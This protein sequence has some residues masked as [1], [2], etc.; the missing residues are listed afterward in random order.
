MQ[1]LKFKKIFLAISS[2]LVIASIVGLIL[3]KLQ[4]SI[5]FTGGSIID[6]TTTEKIDE[7]G[8]NDRL[9][10]G[11][12]ESFILRSTQD[13]F[14]LRTKDTGG[15]NKHNLHVLNAISDNKLDTIKVQ[16]YDTIGPTLGNE[17]KSKAVVSLILVILAITLF[18]AYS[19]RHVSKPVNSWKYGIITMIALVHDVV[20][21]LGVFAF[22]GHFGGIEVDS[23]FITAL[24]VIL[25]Y[26]INDTIVVFDRIREN[27]SHAS[28]SDKENKFDEIVGKSLSETVV[29]SINTSFTTLLATAIVLMFTT[30]SV[31]YFAIA[32]LVGIASGTYSSIF[33]AAPLLTYFKPKNK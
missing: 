12:G 9:Q 10:K 13:G 28:D 7:A 15:D 14:S 22:M 19:F 11:L 1:I 30:G 3:Y 33:V 5:E 29:R 16:K 25:G 2:I 18:I 23:L 8:L 20:I 6:F 27:L 24:L 17:L 26:S 32:L 31:H 4:L 21:T